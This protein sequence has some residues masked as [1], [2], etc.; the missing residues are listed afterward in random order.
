MLNLIQNK[1]FDSFSVYL[2]SS[3]FNGFE[4]EKQNLI[5]N[6]ILKLNELDERIKFENDLI[7][8]SEIQLRENKENKGKKNQFK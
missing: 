2:E 7:E 3:I 1:S 8:V 6:S 4:N 5:I